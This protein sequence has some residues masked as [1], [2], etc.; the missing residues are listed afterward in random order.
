MSETTIAD[1]KGAI[2][3]TVVFG[4]GRRAVVVRAGA[5]PDPVE[6]LE[7]LGVQRGV[8]VVV[9]AGGADTLSGDAHELAARVV[10]PAVARAAAVAKAAVVDGGTAAGVMAI[11]GEAI[12]ERCGEGVVLLG[13][14]P[15]GCVTYPGAPPDAAGDRAALE[16]NHSQFVLADSAQWGGE[17]ALLVAL[18]QALADGAPI[19][20]VVAGG[21][22]VTAQEVLQAARRGWPVFVVVG[23][24]G[25]ADALAAAWRAT[26]ERRPRRFVRVLPKRL[27]RVLPQGWLW[28]KPAGGELADRVQ[29][30]VVRGGDLRLYER[31]DPDELA[32]RL[33]WELQD[34]KVLKL[35]WKS[36]ATYDQLAGAARK[37]FER[38][39]AWILWGGILATLLALLK[40]AIHISPTSSWSWVDGVLHWTVVALP[41][42][43]ATL[44]GM[45]YRLGAGKRWVLLRAAAETIKREIYRVRTAT[46][47]YRQ[48]ASQQDASASAQ[49]L[50]SAQL[51]AIEAKLLQTE[52]SSAELTPH[53]G[54]LPPEMYGASREDD[55]LSP[56]DPERYL[57]F[58]VGDQLSYF[59]PKVAALARTRRRFQV[60]VLAAGGAGA[61][62]AAAGWEVWIGLTT[63]IAGAAL[64]YLG[65]L[66]VESTLV[67]YNQAAGK[68]E[69]LRRGWEA[70]PAARRDRAA[71]EALVADAEAVLATELGGWV[72]QMNEA[73]EE[74]Q[75][76][77]LEQQRQAGIDQKLATS[78]GLSAPP[79]EPPRRSGA[80][81]APED[82]NAP[83][84]G[85]D[86][87]PLQ[88][89]PSGRSRPPG[90]GEQASQQPGEPVDDAADQQATPA[91]S[92]TEATGSATK[93]DS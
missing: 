19:A 12:G 80:S 66:Q 53:A 55:G 35:A 41:L 89:S 60:V 49:E 79:G 14:A 57:A 13:V 22:A 81:V 47:V 84:A 88:D 82:Q 20:M 63:A 77:Q 10:G 61:I 40:G 9:V 62:L 4:N 74:L 44:V 50:L 48:E 92:P 59:H 52:V 42:L 28:R 45:A 26:Y 87:A 21:G 8:P 7:E 33:A 23:S 76:K 90:D 54:P 39:Q 36:F 32:R 93:P 1:G 72:Q 64:A 67:A 18:S 38:L 11:V 91:A 56:L 70:R 2:P 65:Y 27:A 85:P 69:A 31:R 30:E 3:P 29:E 17:T 15:A 71:F 34:R 68:L 43:V 83:N 46:G 37:S 86:P 16:P 24:G 58:R 6:L 5:D 78:D 51:D 25:T 73:L 75:A